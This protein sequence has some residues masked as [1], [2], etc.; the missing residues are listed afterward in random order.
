MARL[1]YLSRTHGRHDQRWVRTLRDAGHSV[2]VALVHETDNHETVDLVVAGPLSD[3]VP[4]A[5]E[6]GDAP[7]LA[8]C[9]AFDVLVEGVDPVVRE[10]MVAALPRCAG[11]HVDCDH[12]RQRVIA[13]GAP[14]ET[15]SV[16][17]WGVDVDHFRPGDPP[18][19]FRAAHGLSPDD[20]VVLSTRSWEEMYDV[21]LV[22]RATAELATLDPRVRLVL[23]GDGS[24]APRIRRQLEEVG[25]ADRCLTPGVLDPV[26][27]RDWLRAS[28]LYVAAAR[29]DGS[30]LSL[31]EALACGVPAVVP[32]VG[33]NPEWVTTPE[34]GR[35]FEVGSRVDLAEAISA[36]LAAPPAERGSRQ[37]RRDLV[38]EKGDW[39][40][41]RLVLLAAVDRVLESAR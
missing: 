19:R 9:W 38:L 29:S 25:L 22:V 33:G 8:L 35:L 1:R 5:V 30:S 14:S 6:R 32:D 37:L 26:A 4:V 24:L 20:R 41:N 16:G 10:R 31:L 3:A 13:L 21:E 34:H 11:V 28:D 12:L 2:D 40:R 27:V 15:V 36:V 18:S 39:S 23:A 7:V 17:A